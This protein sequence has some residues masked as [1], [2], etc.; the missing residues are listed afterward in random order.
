MT[1]FFLYTSFITL[2]YIY[3]DRRGYRLSRSNILVTY[4]IVLAIVFLINIL[5]II[6]IVLLNMYYGYGID[7]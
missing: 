7:R 5:R 4:I 3:L 6:S 1:G 2:E